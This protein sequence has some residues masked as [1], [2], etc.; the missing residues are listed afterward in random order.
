MKASQKVTPLHLSFID[1]EEAVHAGYEFAS[2]TTRYRK[3]AVGNMEN[4]K[5][6][7]RWAHRCS[8]ESSLNNDAWVSSGPK[9]F[10]FEKRNQAFS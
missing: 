5:T 1:Y 4:V 9:G 8:G 2:T 7:G 10:E 3:L 6:Y